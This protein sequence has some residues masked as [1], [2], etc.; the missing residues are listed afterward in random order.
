MNGRC[1]ICGVSGYVVRDHN[2]A[3]GMIRGL[4]C[5]PCNG[6]IAAYERDLGRS[7]RRKHK[8]EFL[9]WFYAHHRAILTHLLKDTGVRYS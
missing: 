1:E 4:L 3:T 2:H 9:L 8:R 5:D 7:R 6:R